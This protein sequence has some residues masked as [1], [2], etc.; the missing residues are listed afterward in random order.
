MS[1]PRNVI[2]FPLDR[3]RQRV[4]TGF[5]CPQCQRAPEYAKVGPA[6]VC[7]CSHCVLYWVRYPDAQSGDGPVSP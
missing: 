7:H 3:T 5:F 2:P 1:A 4:H 6:H